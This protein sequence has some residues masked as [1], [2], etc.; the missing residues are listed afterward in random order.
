MLK[1]GLQEMEQGESVT[2][3]TDNNTSLKNLVTYLRD[4]G[5]EPEVKARKIYIPL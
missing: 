3:H 1:E 2:I 4:Q 5:V